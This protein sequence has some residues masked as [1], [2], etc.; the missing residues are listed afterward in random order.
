VLVPVATAGPAPM[1]VMRAI[2]TILAE[3]ELML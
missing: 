1:N 2:D 3:R